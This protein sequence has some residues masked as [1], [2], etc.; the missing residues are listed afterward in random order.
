MFSQK[1]VESDAF[2]DMP[3]TSQSLYFHL[4]MYADDDGFVGSPKKISKIIGSN[5]DD[6]KILIAKRFVLTFENG[7]IVVKHWLIHNLIRSDLYHETQYKKE[8]SLLGL[9]ENGAYTELKNGVTEI[10]KIEPPKWLIKRKG[11]VCTDNVTQTAHRLGKDRIGKVSITANKKLAMGT[12][13]K[14]IN[15]EKNNIVSDKSNKGIGNLQKRGVP[16][17][18]EA[19]LIQ[20]WSDKW[21][22]TF[23]E[24]PIITSWGRYIKQAKPF[25]K[26][27]GLDRCKKICDTY[28]ITS[29]KFSQDNKWALG[30]FLT[31]NVFN[32][33]AITC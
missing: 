33:L 6:M 31:D 22:K 32:K 9:N 24:K 12:S 30:I 28:F 5:D 27:Y 7:I 1:I 20:Y 15:K 19:E 11:L 4:G 16:T 3:A 23:S 25:V 21:E 18:E 8:K 29:D 2:L 26:E 17:S 14:R 10:K 13:L